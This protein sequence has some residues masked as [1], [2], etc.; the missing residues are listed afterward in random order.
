MEK[1][2]GTYL[3][4]LDGTHPV[5]CFNE[6]PLQLV[7]EVRETIDAAPGRP[8]RKDCEYERCGVAEVMM[9]CQ[10]AARLHKCMV[11]AQENRLCGR[12]RE[13]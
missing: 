3:L 7:R 12:V 13:D 8:R 6:S 5:M 2:I 9:I 4:A 10:P 1:V 11:M